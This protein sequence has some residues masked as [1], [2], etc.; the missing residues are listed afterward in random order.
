M[1]IT[2]QAAALPTVE[3]K[4]FR[5]LQLAM[6]I[7]C[8]AMIANLQ[9][10]WTLFVDPI[11]AKFHWGRAAI[12]FAFTLFVLTETWLVPVEAWFVDKYGP[13]IVVMFG[14]VMIAFAWVLNSYAASLTLLYVAAVFG[15]IGAGSVYG[16]CVGKASR[17]SPLNAV[18]C[19]RP[20]SVIA[21][22]PVQCDA[23]LYPGELRVNNVRVKYAKP[24]VSTFQ[25]PAGTKR[26]AMRIAGGRQ[27]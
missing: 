6:G 24:C 23:N 19:L 21:K 25:R 16:T 26:R 8:M 3:A 12:Q 22:T 2:I 17:C 4:N 27:C 5:W 9:Y 7:A 14:G 13:R 10:G 11:D 18:T 15:G 1:T 20:G